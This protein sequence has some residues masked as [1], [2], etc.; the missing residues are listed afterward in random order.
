[1]HPLPL[2]LPQDSRKP[3]LPQLQPTVS[4]LCGQD[5][6][7]LLF[8]T[9]ALPISQL[10]R[11]TLCILGVFVPIFLLDGPCKAQCHSGT[12]RQERTQSNRQSAADGG[13]PDKN[14]V[15]LPCSFRLR[16]CAACWCGLLNLHIRRLKSHR[17]YTRHRQVAVPTQHKEPRQYYSTKDSQSQLVRMNQTEE[18]AFWYEVVDI[19]I[20]A[21]FQYDE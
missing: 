7:A 2:P 14:D 9:P 16:S 8:A 10:S 19:S 5:G 15:M 12:F 4:L 20:G 18:G 3:Q 6:S 17:R 21:L 1:M 11:F 13:R